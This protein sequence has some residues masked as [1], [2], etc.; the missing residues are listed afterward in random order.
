MACG[1]ASGRGDL[2]DQRRNSEPPRRSPTPATNPL[3]STHST[4]LCSGAAPRL[5]LSFVLVAFVTPLE[6]PPWCST[7]SVQYAAFVTQQLK[8]LSVLD[9]GLDPLVYVLRMAE[10]KGG[11]EKLLDGEDNLW[12]EFGVWG[13]LCRLVLEGVVEGGLWERRVGTPRRVRREKGA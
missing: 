10:E 13:G 3:R 8:S 11:E 9:R 12:C 2:L 6:V 7:R 1:I 5:T 4:S